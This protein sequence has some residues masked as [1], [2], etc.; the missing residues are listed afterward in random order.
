M[1]HGLD[2]CEHQQICI[3][4]VGFVNEKRQKKRLVYMFAS[5]NYCSTEHKI[6][7]MLSY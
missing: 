1:P 7:D 5:Y 6:D 4:D 3:I 2:L